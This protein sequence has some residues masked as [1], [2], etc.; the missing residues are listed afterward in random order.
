MTRP[1]I[2]EWGHCM[3]TALALGGLLLVLRLVGFHRATAFLSGTVMD[4]SGSLSGQVLQGCLY[5]ACHVTFWIFAPPLCA[6][7]LMLRLSA[8]LRPRPKS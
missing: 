4:G 8:W 2:P 3:L 1:R 6:L 7:A 5:I